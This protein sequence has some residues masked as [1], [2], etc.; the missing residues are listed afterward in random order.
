MNFESL[1]NYY[2]H[3]V[4]EYVTS[5]LTAKYADEDEEFFLDVACYALSRLPPRYIRHEVDMMYYLGQ[6]ERAEMDKEVE[7]QVTAA[8]SFI[9]GREKNNQLHYQIA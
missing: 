2:E 7:L 3:L 8:A 1:T 6:K 4:Y 5:Q 9:K